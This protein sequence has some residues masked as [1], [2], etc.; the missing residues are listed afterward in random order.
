M[1]ELNH[2]G[3]VLEDNVVVRL[4]KVHV[5]VEGQEKNVIAGVLGDQWD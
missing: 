3:L 5:L 1:E 2:C 4:W